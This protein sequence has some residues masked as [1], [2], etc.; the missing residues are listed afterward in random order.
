[1]FIKLRLEKNTPKLY[2]NFKKSVNIQLLDRER[3]KKHIAQDISLLQS[4]CDTL[5]KKISWQ[6]THV[7]YIRNYEVR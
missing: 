1:M 3:L 7:E 4:E 6:K 5:D 2:E